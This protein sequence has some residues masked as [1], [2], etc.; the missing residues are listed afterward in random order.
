MTDLETPGPATTVAA[1]VPPTTV[2]TPAV[3][4]PDPDEQAAAEHAYMDQTGKQVVPLATFLESKK[5]L[6]ATEVR[7]KETEAKAQ[8]LE[9]WAQQWQPYLSAL[10]NRPDLLQQALGQTAPSREATAQPQDDP[11]AEH[12]ARELDLY[13]PQGQPDTARAARMLKVMDAR[14]ERRVQ[15]EVEPV[16]LA[17]EEAKATALRQQAFDYVQRTG[18]APPQALQ[19]VLAMI[20]PALQGDANVMNLALVLARGIGSGGTTPLTAPASG[21]MGPLTEPLVTEAPGRRAGPAPLSEMEQRVVANRGIAPDR[22]RKLTD[23]SPILE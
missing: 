15:R 6:K 4:T 19:Q 23:S 22:W 17:S 11:E 8:Q 1:D 16:K 2:A 20:P 14:V 5:Q 3:T 21:P 13:T 18:Y 12:L 9:A 7:A 10:A